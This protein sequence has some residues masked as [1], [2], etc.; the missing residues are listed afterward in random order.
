M[1]SITTDYVKSTGSPAPYLRRIAKAGFSY[2]HWR[3]QWNTDFLYANS[4]IDQIGK[5][6]KEYGLQLNDL[7]AS[8]GKEKS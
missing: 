7:H 5:W 2:V 6:F 4:E 8:E 1:H 3:H